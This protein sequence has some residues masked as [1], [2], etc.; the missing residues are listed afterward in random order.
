MKNII[1][2]CASGMSTSLLV[3][4]MEKEVKNA[5]LDIAIKAISVI[6][7][8][9]NIQNADLFLLGPQVKHELKKLQPI[10]ESAGKKIAV[11]DMMDYGM[12]KGDKVLEKALILMDMK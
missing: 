4:K 11:I 5:G 3:Q 8:N 1:L 12:L 7:F 2:C 9:D 10:A 6:E